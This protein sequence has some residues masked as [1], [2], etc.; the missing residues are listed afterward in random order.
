M[1]DEQIVQRV[2]QIV[3]ALEKVIPEVLAASIIGSAS[4]SFPTKPGDIDILIITHSAHN[5]RELADTL[6]KDLFMEGYPKW[7]AM[8]DILTCQEGD[9]K[10]MLSV[11]SKAS[12]DAR[13]D[14]VV[15]GHE[16]KPTYELWAI[17]G[18]VPEVLCADVIDARIV[19]ERQ[20]C[21]SQW[22]EN[23]CM[24]PGKLRYSILTTCYEE[25]RNKVLAANQ[26]LLLGDS[27]T[28]ECAIFSCFLPLLR[29]YFALERQYFRGMKHLQNQLDFYLPNR[30]DNINFI[31]GQSPLSSSQKIVF[32]NNAID[33]IREELVAT[34]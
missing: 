3:Y 12:L 27:L 25:L 30:I 11:W 15:S 21:I 34:T 16:L 18:V 19:I 4:R 14:A 1:V 20:N 10:V 26:S 33:N 9:F 28:M 29:A 32:L 31:R 5:M 24:Y 6:E 17:G 8:D 7:N 23:L 22:K 2:S 13:L